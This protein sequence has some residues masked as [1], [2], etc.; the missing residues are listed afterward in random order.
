MMNNQTQIIF[1]AHPEPIRDYIVVYQK[2]ESC[3]VREHLNDR[4]QTKLSNWYTPSRVWRKTKREAEEWVEFLK[5]FRHI[6]SVEIIKITQEEAELPK[7]QQ[8]LYKLAERYCKRIKL[9]QA[10]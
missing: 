6:D 9:N 3:R 4:F 10:K 7:N 8:T 1:P 2:R 5:K